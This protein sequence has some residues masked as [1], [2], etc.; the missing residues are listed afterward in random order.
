MD[1]GHVRIHPLRSYHSARVRFILSIVPSAELTGQISITL[2]RF[3]T[4]NG[5][6]TVVC[7]VWSS[8]N[9]SFLELLTLAVEIVLVVRG[10]H[11][12]IEL[13]RRTTLIFRV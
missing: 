8:W 5:H 1:Q 4:L 13:R 6:T 2:L 3:R 9:L 12:T 7:R 10:S 11:R